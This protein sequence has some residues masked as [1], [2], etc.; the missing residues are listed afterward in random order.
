MRTIEYIENVVCAGENVDPDTLHT[1]SRERR[2][3]EIRQ[4]IMTLA[5]EFNN[6][7]EVAG[8]YFN[9]NHC[10]A[11]NARRVI[12]ALSDTDKLWNL[13]LRL[14]RNII[15]SGKTY[16][17]WEFED[18]KARIIGEAQQIIKDIEKIAI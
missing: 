18:R 5:L 4:L 14:Y 16:T 3:L 12:Y 10:T 1:T 7:Q 9:K 13:K 15:G 11:L 2:F 6:T 17:A 8:A